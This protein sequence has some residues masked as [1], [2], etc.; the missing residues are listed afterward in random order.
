M[1]KFI[2]LTGQ[3]FGR[4]TVIERVHSLKSLQAMWLCKCECGN[5]AV[6]RGADL[7]LGKSTS[8][9]CYNKEVVSATRKKHGCS[10]TAI[11][12]VWCDILRRC[13][14]DKNK[15]YKDYGARGIGV[16]DA[17]RHHPD[18]FVD[19]AKRNG[20]QKGLQIDR[21]D[22]NLGYSPDNCRFVEAHTNTNNRRITVKF[23]NGE[24]VA[25]VC[26]S[27]GIIPTYTDGGRGSVYR[28]V[29]RF[30]DKHKKLHPAFMDACISKGV[31]PGRFLRPKEML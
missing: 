11:Y 2:D 22:N 31:C 7:R 19:W 15:Y 24:S 13:Y 14:D 5:E 9:G 3:T 12:H 21:I 1:G 10:G 18:M 17:W 6:V 28:R 27:V 25:E 23:S 30:W 20:Y 4:L 26:R 29:L 16:C 8:C